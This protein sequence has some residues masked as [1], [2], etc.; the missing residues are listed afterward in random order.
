MLVLSTLRLIITPV[1]FLLLLGSTFELSLHP[2]LEG[3]IVVYNIL[4]ACIYFEKIYCSY[5]VISTLTI[6][7]FLYI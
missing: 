5:V 7:H 6:V 4:K 2:Q 3:R 1:L